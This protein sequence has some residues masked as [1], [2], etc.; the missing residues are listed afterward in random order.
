MADPRSET[1]CFSGYRIEKMP[2]PADDTAAVGALSAALDHAVA[3]AA[4]RGYIRFLSGM[5][6]GF[7]LW[8]AEAVLRARAR[9]P[10]QL[11]CAVPFDRQADRYPPVWK[12]AFNRCLLEADRVY[13]LSRRYYAGCYAARNR[14]MV[15]GSSLLICYYDG[16]PGGTAQTVRM[17]RQAGM[18]I[19]NLADGQLDLFGTAVL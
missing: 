15:D 10:V 19:Q 5:S 9:L 8:A 18:E 11:L 3:Q 1:C 12:R 16:R 13:S 4:A 6:T 17:A 14:F 7:D 2:F